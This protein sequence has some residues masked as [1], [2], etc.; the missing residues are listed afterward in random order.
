MQKFLFGAVLAAALGAAHIAAAQTT[1][2][3]TLGQAATRMQQSCVATGFSVSECAC[4]TGF[5]SGRLQ[6][7]EFHLLAVLNGFVGPDGQ[8]QDMP[9][10]QRA[11][12]AEASRLGVNDQRFQQIMQRFSEMPR[13]GAYADRVCVPL[14]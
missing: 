6:A 13:D 5:Y 9:A 3:A 8:V 11:L 2:E 1:A 14:R 10:A 12:L 4:M 7:D